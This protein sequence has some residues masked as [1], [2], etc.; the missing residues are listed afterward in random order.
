MEYK[1]FAQIQLLFTVLVLLTRATDGDV[2]YSIQEEMKQGSVIGNIAK[3]LGL[4]VNM[5]SARNARIDA[6]SNRKRYSNVN[7]KTGD[8]IVAERIDRDGLCGKKASCVLKQ[9]LVL[10]NPLELHRVS[11]H[12]QDV[13]DN[14]PHFKKEVIE[15]EIA[16]SADK[17][18]R[19]LLE[20]A[21]DADIGQNA[22][23]SYTLQSND[24]FTLSVQSNSIGGKYSELILNKELDREQQQELTLVLSA[25]DGGVPPRSGTVAIHVTVLDANDNAPVFSQSVY[26]VSLPENSPLDTVVATVSATDADV[27]ANGEVRYEFGHV[28][29][30]DLKL[31]SLDP[32]SG[33]I[34]V[35]GPIDFEEESSYELRVQVKDGAGLVSYC[36]VI[37]DVTDVNDN[38][39]VIYLKSLI[40]PVPENVPPGTEVGLLNVQ[41]RDSEN[42]ERVRCFINEAVPFKLVPS[43]KNYYSLVTTGDLD[44]ELV[45]GYNFTV[46]A[47]DEGSPSLSSIRYVQLSV[48]DVN[49]NP[50]V[51]EKQS[52]KAHITENNKPGSSICSIV[53]RDPDWRQNGTVF[54]SLSPTEVNGIPVS[55]FVSING[56]TG[57]IHTVKSLD[58]EQFKTF[59]VYVVARDNGSPPLSSNVTVSVF[60]MDEN[61]NTPQILYPAPEGNS[62]MTELVPRSAHAG[63]LVSKVIAVDADSGQNSWLSYNIIKSTDQG[64]FTIGVHSGEILTQ[65]DIA[66]SDAMKQ[67]IIVSVTDNG[68]PSL[69]ATCVVYLIVSDSLADI[70]EVKDMSR[71]ESSSKLTSYLILALVS[72]ST[73]FVTFLIII[74]TVKFCRRRKPRLLFDGAVAIPSAYLP[75]NYADVDGTGTLRSCYNYDRYMTTG[76]RTSDFKFV[77]SY[78]GA[79][80]PADLTMKKSPSAAI[81]D[82]LDEPNEQKPPNQDWR[83]NQNQRPGPSGAAATPEVAVGTGPWPNP[84]TEAEQLQALMAAA[85][86]A[87][88]TSSPPLYSSPRSCLL[89][90]EVSEAT[91]TLTPGTMGLST[92]YSPQFTLQHVPD[93]RQNVYIPGSTATLT[94]NPQQQQQQQLQLQQQMLPNMPP[95]QALPPAQATG[96]DGAAGGGAPGAQSEPPKAAQTPAS[97]KKSTKK[98]KK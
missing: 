31:F 64:L 42:N 50:P 10:E 15:L 98:E 39:P 21:H 70:P 45:S 37:I 41:D 4:T 47:A 76:S 73:L 3:D 17:G 22:V 68:K 20:E 94:S 7:I 13:N 44:R 69:S 25:I 61:D 52:Y 97:K 40:N 53:A 32:V 60:V 77:S 26:K 23:E 5:L 56:D 51:F 78:N 29:E 95:Q 11:L 66:E 8:L 80:L 75:P 54:Y 38:A 86:G 48:A 58:Y 16:E 74:L 84:P 71:D 59:D 43:I 90:S 79:T 36:T 1:G 92:R 81:N 67:N 46:T 89:I 65:R 83:F 30:E 19:F 33:E 24:H 91:N 63:S 96:P 62:L 18:A 2:S 27:G 55:S 82:L 35:T 14:S 87:S 6:E 9:E 34:R 28:S 12:V 49:D 72:V 85:N 93:Y 57:V 88:H